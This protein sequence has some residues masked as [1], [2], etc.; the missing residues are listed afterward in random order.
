MDAKNTVPSHFGDWQYLKK[1]ICRGTS[2]P[3]SYAPFVFYFLLAIIGLGCLGIWVELIKVLLSANTQN[4]DRMLTALGTFFPALIGS[5]AFRLILASTD[6]RDKIFA[7]FGFGMCLL[8]FA[9][10]ILISL[11]HVSFP[12]VTLCAAVAFAGF[13]IWLWWFANGDDPVFKSNLPIDAPSGG[14]TSKSLKGDTSG[15]RE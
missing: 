10:A 7:S 3:L 14:D 8:A 2:Q 12:I 6:K 13:A 9:A 4:F 5:S 15:F 11:L 1:E